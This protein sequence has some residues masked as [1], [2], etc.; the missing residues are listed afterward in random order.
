MRH[1][2]Q[3]KCLPHSSVLINTHL[4]VLTETGIEFDVPV[5]KLRFPGHGKVDDALEEAAT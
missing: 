5:G 4:D 1:G 3:E 2:N